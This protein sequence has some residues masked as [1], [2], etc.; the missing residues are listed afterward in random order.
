[1]RSTFSIRES[2]DTG[3]WIVLNLDKG[4]LGEQSATLGAVFF[5][6]IKNALFSRRNRDLFTLYCDE[7]QNL[8]GYAAGLETVLSE[9]R[10]FATPIVSANQFLDQYPAEMRAAILSVG[11]HVF[12]QLSSTDAQQIANSLDGGKPLA[13]RL[14]NLPRRHIIAKI[15]HEPWQQATVPTVRPPKAGPSDLYDRSRKRW[16]RSRGEVEAEI[17]ERQALVS[18]TPEEHLHEWE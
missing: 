9:A 7:I 5:T 13:E 12:F 18:R 3:R 11:S 15:G 6:A 10:K 14:K 8:V 2:I 16:A 17:A 1:V 4:R